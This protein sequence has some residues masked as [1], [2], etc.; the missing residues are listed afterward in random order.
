MSDTTKRII[1]TDSEGVKILIPSP[2]SP[3][4]IEELQNKDVP[5]GVESYIVPVQSVPKDRSFRNAWT[6]SP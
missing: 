6:Y 4:T 5:N 2:N 1:Y 3:R